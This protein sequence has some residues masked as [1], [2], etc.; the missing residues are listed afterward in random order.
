MNAVYQAPTQDIGSL[1]D[2]LG[3]DLGVLGSEERKADNA[4]ESSMAQKNALMRQNFVD[5]TPLKEELAF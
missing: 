2:R 5:G 3:S 4:H 1:Y